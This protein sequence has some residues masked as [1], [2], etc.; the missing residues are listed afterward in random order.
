MI[1]ENI[2]T[3]LIK[4]ILTFCLRLFY[5]LSLLTVLDG[6]LCGIYFSYAS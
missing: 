4:F 6:I 2:L 3:F 1:S 5:M